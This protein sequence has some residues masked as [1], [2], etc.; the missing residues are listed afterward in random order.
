MILYFS[1]ANVT[2]TILNDQQKLQKFEM[3]LKVKQWTWKRIM[4]QNIFQVKF[5]DPLWQGL[6]DIQELFFKNRF[7][8]CTLYRNVASLKFHTKNFLLKQIFYFLDKW[9]S[10]IAR[11]D[12]ILQMKIGV[13]DRQNCFI[14][15]II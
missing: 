3:V 14:G 5:Y 10:S 7:M 4:S 11:W 15:F 12:P 6:I 1:K 9:V 13:D 8:V 2:Y